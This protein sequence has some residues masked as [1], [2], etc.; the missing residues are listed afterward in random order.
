[1]QLMKA[2]RWLLLQQRLHLKPRL[3]QQKLFPVP[4]KAQAK[5]HQ[6]SQNQFLNSKFCRED[7]MDKMIEKGKKLIENGE[8]QN[9][10]EYFSALLVKPEQRL[11][12]HKWLARLDFIEGNPEGALQQLEAAEAID[13]QD[14][15]TKA[16]KGLYYVE[17]ERYPEALKVLESVDSSQPGLAFNYANL[18]TAYR[19]L[20]RIGDAMEAAI[21]AVQFSPGDPAAHFALSQALAVDGKIEDAIYETLETLKINPSHLMAYVFL[22][23]LYRQAG[24]TDIVIELY[25]EC[26]RHVPEA[27]PVREEVVELLS[28]KNDHAAALVHARILA[29]HRGLPKDFF[30]LG[31]LY[32]Q[33]G[34]G[35]E[36]IAAYSSGIA[37]DPENAVMLNTLGLA[38]VRTRHPA[39]GE[40]YLKKAIELMPER[41]EPVLNLAIGYATQQR[42]EDAKEYANRVIEGAE[43]TNSIRKEAKRLLGAIAKEESTLSN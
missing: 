43:S 34:M 31:D 9:A 11:P 25:M 19:E 8:F 7:E 6:T 15:E 21:K 2:P 14:N 27:D 12:A 35:E 38:L 30:N 26:L 17:L 42:W 4:Q 33:C 10:Q 41:F 24:Q 16:L 39:E 13:P 40:P 3:L 28:A 5:P 29:E 22:G 36:A 20:D 23:S 37:L 18:S 32:A 1:M